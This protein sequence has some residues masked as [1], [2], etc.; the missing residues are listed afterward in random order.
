MPPL[1]TNRRIGAI[2]RKSCSVS[3]LP[4]YCWH[5]FECPRVGCL[6]LSNLL[7]SIASLSLA[8]D[9]LLDNP[10]N[11]MGRITRFAN[12]AQQLTD[13][14]SRCNPI[15]GFG[16]D[17]RDQQFEGRERRPD[18]PEL[19]CDFP[20]ELLGRPAAIMLDV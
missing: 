16:I 15:T 8:S 20:E 5:L 18:I 3:R 2:R 11:L 17:S 10:K 19:V 9:S 14:R 12:L 4:F 6:L 7:F 1:R 13:P